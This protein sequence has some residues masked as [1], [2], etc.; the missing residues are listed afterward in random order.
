MLVTRGISD[1]VGLRRADDWTKY[2]C[3]S[4]AAFTRAFL[5]TPPI[6]LGSAATRAAERSPK[7]TNKTNQAQA[8]QNRSAGPLQTQEKRM[9]ADMLLTWLSNLLPPQFE[10]VLYRA[11]IPPRH[12]PGPSAPQTERAV[13]AM[14]YIEQQNQL[15]QLAG[16]VEQVVHG[17]SEQADSDPR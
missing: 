6:E 14:R 9:T 4:A 12:L 2:A 1:T 15:D 10:E 5:C 7:V 17:G 3:A 11:N 13:G 16:I 8:R